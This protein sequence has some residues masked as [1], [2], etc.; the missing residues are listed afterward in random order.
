MDI[1]LLLILIRQM[2]ALVR[3]ALA[4]VCT[5]PLL[6]VVLCNVHSECTK[7]RLCRKNADLEQTGNSPQ[8]VLKL[9]GCS[10]SLCG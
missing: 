1:N 10:V 3:H 4:E 8:V 2:V 7:I 6:L 9:P 5:V